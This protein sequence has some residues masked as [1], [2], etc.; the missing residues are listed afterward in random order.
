MPSTSRTAKWKVVNGSTAKPRTRRA[1]ASTTTPTLLCP[2]I[3]YLKGSDMSLSFHDE[4]K[5]AE[6]LG[7]KTK[8]ST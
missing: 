8:T 5:E 4:A 2:F 7:L 6:S 3:G 1:L